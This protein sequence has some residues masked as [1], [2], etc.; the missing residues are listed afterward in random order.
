MKPPLSFIYTFRRE[1][2]NAAG[3]IGNNPLP[4]DVYYSL[5]S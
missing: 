1:K 5:K 2:R 4:I 3:H